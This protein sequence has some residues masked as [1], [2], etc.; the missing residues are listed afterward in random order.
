MCHQDIELVEIRIQAPVRS[1]LKSPDGV[2]RV[3]QESIEFYGITSNGTY[4][5]LTGDAV[6]VNPLYQPKVTRGITEALSIM[7]RRLP[8]HAFREE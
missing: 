8:Q 3:H 6:D 4:V 7:V 1:F 5:L 2:E